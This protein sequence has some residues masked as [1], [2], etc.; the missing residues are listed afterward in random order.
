MTAFTN[1]AE[2]PGGSRSVRSGGDGQPLPFSGTEL[3]GIAEVQGS[4]F[5]VRGPESGVRSLEP[6][7]RSQQPDVRSRESEA[8]SQQPDLGS[9][10]SEARSERLEVQIPNSEA[11]DPE[12]RMANHASR[13][14]SHEPRVA[15]PGSSPV[16]SV[17]R[18]YSA[19]A[20]A[21]TGRMPSYIESLATDMFTDGATLQEVVAAAQRQ[22]FRRVTAA[23]LKRWL[24][25]NPSV[26]VRAIRRQVE[27][28]EALKNSLKAGDASPGARLAEAA[29]FAGLSHPAHNAPPVDLREL[30]QIQSS[31]WAEL[32]RE[33]LTL[34]RR[35]KKLEARKES[36][37][38]RIERARMRVERMRLE[39]VGERLGELRDRLES[40]QPQAAPPEP[41]RSAAAEIVRSLCRLLAPRPGE[42]DPEED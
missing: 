39:V 23:R 3:G 33:N 16:V 7:L 24:L 29:L 1:V 27:A 10:E 9:R 8:G 20:R 14:P 5:A 21:R 36:I 17:R 30:A 15:T 40:P 26:R 2:T 11:A 35:A 25:K 28:A 4:E 22:G 32:E 31:I 6:E 41:V 37:K 38:R 42:E 12:P 13:V 34:K 19:D 18:R